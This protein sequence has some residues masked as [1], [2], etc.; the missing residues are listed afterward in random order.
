[1]SITDPI[2][3][4]N[5]QVHILIPKLLKEYLTLYAAEDQCDLNNEIIKRLSATFKNTELFNSIEMIVTNSIKII[6]SDQQ[7]AS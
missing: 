1:M 7:G 4:N 6:L 2:Q 5:T 3:Q